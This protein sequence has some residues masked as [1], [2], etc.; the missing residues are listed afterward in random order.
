MRGKT[1]GNIVLFI[2]IKVLITGWGFEKLY[3][4]YSSLEEDGV[5]YCTLRQNLFQRPNGFCF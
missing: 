5:T 1:G 4:G 2:H 3:L